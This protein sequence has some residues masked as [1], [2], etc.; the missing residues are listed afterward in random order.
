M[1]PDPVKTCADC[2]EALVAAGVYPAARAVRA[3]WVRRCGEGP[4]YRDLLPILRRWVLKR[5]NSRRVRALVKSYGRLDPV[6]RM[7]FAE[8]LAKEGSTT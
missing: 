6:E 4:S 3:E 2:C 7:A 1:R 8:L 5:R